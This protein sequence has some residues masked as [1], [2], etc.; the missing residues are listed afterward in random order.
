MQFE[1]EFFGHKNIRSNHQNTIEITRES[2][3]TPSGDC[4]VGVRASSACADLPDD[5]KK[6]LENPNAL[7]SFTFTVGQYEFVVYGAGHADLTLSHKEDIVL[8]KS[9]FTCPR[10]IS[11]KCDKAS[12]DIPREMIHLLQDPDTRGTLTIRI[13]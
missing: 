12:N 9:N 10:T 1:I 3:L 2:D 4:I 7:V 6:S 5:M 8:R 11:V 13:D